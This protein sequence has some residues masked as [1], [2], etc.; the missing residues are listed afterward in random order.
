MIRTLALGAVLLGFAAGQAQA[1][2]YPPDGYPPRGY[3][4]RGYGPPVEYGPPGS[5]CDAYFE[6]RYGGDR[7][8]LCEM[9]VAKPVGAPCTCPPRNPY[10]PPAQGR[11]IP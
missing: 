1:Q 2:Y 10:G 9:G 11:V 8:R 4:P 7:R 5:R 3:G 6:D